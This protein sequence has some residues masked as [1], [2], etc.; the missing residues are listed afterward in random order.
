MRKWHRWL[1]VIFGVFLLF[2]ATTGVLSQFAALKA[3][4]EPRPVAAA[5]AGF[6]CPET[7]MCRPKPN[8]DG[9]AP[10]VSYLHH[11]HSGEEFGP[12]G[13]AISIMSGFALIFFSFSGL[14]LYIAMWRNRA[15]RGVKPG[16]FWK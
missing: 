3:D 12:V 13:T 14:W 15:S 7:M 5:P 16:W 11:L 2:I 8:P 6:V 9:A 4:S 10:W 1:S